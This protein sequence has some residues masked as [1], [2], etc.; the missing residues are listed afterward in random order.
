[1]LAGHRWPSWQ[2]LQVHISTS[3]FST[4]KQYWLRDHKAVPKRNTELCI[5]CPRSTTKVSLPPHLLI[6]NESFAHPPAYPQPFPLPCSSVCVPVR[7]PAHWLIR[8][9]V[10]APAQHPCHVCIARVALPCV[11]RLLRLLCQHA[12]VGVLACTE[13]KRPQRLTRATATWRGGGLCCR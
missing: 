11:L 2:E 8:T 4:H 13:A 10:D 1:L 6:S 9:N 3:I 5:S 7:L 12:R